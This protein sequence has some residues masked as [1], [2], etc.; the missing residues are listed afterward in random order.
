MTMDPAR[1]ET[2][3]DDQGNGQASAATPIEILD[4]VK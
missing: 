1:Y 2:F 3:P 4:G